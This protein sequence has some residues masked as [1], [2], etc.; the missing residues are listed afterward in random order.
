MHCLNIL[1]PFEK[2]KKLARKGSGD[3]KWVAR[4]K[5]NASSVEM[6]VKKAMRSVYSTDII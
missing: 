4:V 3:T 1:K 2:S 6:A 5:A